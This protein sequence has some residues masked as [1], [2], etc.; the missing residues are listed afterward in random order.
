ME[1]LE[2]GE[3]A[4]RA[5][6]P[7]E[8]RELLASNKAS[9]IDIRGDDEWRS[10]HIPGAR[11]RAADEVE[12]ALAKIDDAQTVIIAC[13]DGEKS[14]RIAAGLAGQGGREAVSIE[15]GMAS[16]RSDDMPMQ[17]STDVEDGTAI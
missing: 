7:T 1:R 3:T 14:K 17:P 6:G 13:E 10:G 9:A 11:H 8:A 12:T 4:A 5:I 15:G 16:W 2:T